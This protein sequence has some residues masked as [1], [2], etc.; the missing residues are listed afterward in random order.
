MDALRARN[1]G[2]YG[3]ERKTSP[4]IDGL[5][6][7]GILFENVFSTNNSTNPSFLSIHS[8]RHLLKTELSSFIYTKEEMK[9]FFNSGGIFL[10]EI[11]KKKGYKTY[12]LNKLYTWQKAG[13]DHFWDSDEALQERKVKNNKWPFFKLFKKGYYFLAS[14]PGLLFLIRNKIF[15]EVRPFPSGEKST[16]EAISLIKKSKENKESF[17]MRI[18]YNDTHMPY[19]NPGEFEKKFIAKE[20]GALLFKNL[21]EKNI[22]KRLLAISR[23]FFGEKIG[24][25]EVI[26]KYDSAI[27]Y[28]DHLIGKVIKTLEETGLMENTYIFFFSDHGESFNEHGVYLNHTGLYD[29]VMNV[30][31]IITG[32]NISKAKRI[33]GLV[34]LED[35]M[36]TVLD[37]L[38]IDHTP[39]DFEGQSLNQLIKGKKKKLRDSLFIEEI[40][41]LKRKGFRTESHKYIETNS[42]QE[43]KKIKELYDLVK[44]PKETKNLAEEKP[45]LTEKLEKSMNEYLNS[46]RK[47]NEKR[48]IAQTL[49]KIKL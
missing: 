22:N 23:I 45:E 29:E 13:F 6:N 46:L 3:Y 10:Q 17:F 20:K 27:S 12:C 15:K 40:I 49:S 39:A 5:A 21:S 26:A 25:N 7:K 14:K 11:L 35:L 33:K 44:D 16:E 38:E 28:N 9:Y 31:L 36:P 42:T 43:G 4:N 48:R 18:D 24:M 19:N 2:C 34:Q 30:P 32:P 1:L 37:F 41:D 47:T 8:G